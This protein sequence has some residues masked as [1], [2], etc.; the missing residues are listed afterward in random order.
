ML[1]RL[2]CRWG[3]QSVKI[4]VLPLISDVGIEPRFASTYLALIAKLKSSDAPTDRIPFF[5]SV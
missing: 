2:L 5:G 1:Q 4:A 3:G